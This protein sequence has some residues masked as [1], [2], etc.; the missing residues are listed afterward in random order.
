[1]LLDIQEALQIGKAM[2]AEGKLQLDVIWD[3]KQITGVSIRSSRPL[4]AC[5]ILEGKPAAEAVRLV[6][7]LFSVCGRAQG[8]A[9]AA[10]C[11]AARGVAPNDVERVARERA[12]AGECLQEYTWRLLIDLPA[13][14]GEAARPGEL[15]DL[16]R[17]IATARDEL[18][19]H[20]V[21]GAAEELLERAV[22]EMSPRVWL[23]LRPAAFEKWVAR[24]DAPMQRMLARLRTLRLG[25]DFGLL[26]WLEAADLGALSARL[27]AEPDFAQR[28]DWQG[29]PAE[30]GA[31]ARQLGHPVLAR[32]VG[33]YGATV[34][35]RLLA[36]LLEL[37]QLPEQLRQP[38]ASG[39]RSASPRQGSGI[40]QGDF[41]R[42]VAAVETA[43]GTLLHQ[44]TLAGD[45]VAH[46]RIVAPTEWNFHPQG[47]F[48][49]GLL[50]CPAKSETEARGAAGLLAHALDPCVAYEVSVAR[51]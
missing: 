39:I 27:E 2:I 22:Y 4:A 42:G 12:I 21:A 17:R 28:P 16:R 14:L 20:D 3:G 5:R 8:A 10:A 36:R 13:L 29:E 23:G 49:R 35:A 7:L 31:L 32:E 9:A 25:G 34:A 48:V 26:P 24:G 51:A 30:T 44:V 15:A 45:R 50:G 37:A 43:R 11:E 33:Q 47:A 6:P 41:R 1:M 40:P 18:R 38:Q 19:W 46:Y